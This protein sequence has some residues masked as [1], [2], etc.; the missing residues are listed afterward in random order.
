MSDNVL[1]FYFV[2]TRVRSQ[3]FATI[4]F[5]VVTKDMKKL[6]YDVLPSDL[7]NPTIVESAVI[8]QKAGDGAP[9]T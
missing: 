2:V 4:S 9:E 5:N 1:C 8:A 7:S 6:G 3:G